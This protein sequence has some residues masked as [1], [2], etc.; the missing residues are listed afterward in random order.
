MKQSTGRYAVREVPGG[1]VYTLE[2]YAVVLECDCGERMLYADAACFR[3]RCGA[4]HEKSVR[5]LMHPE[6]VPWYENHSGWLDED[7]ILHPGY[8]EWLE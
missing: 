8:K 2:P 4:D 5:R 1:K 6:S 3:C 7:A